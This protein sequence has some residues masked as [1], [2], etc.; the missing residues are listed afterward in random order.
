M[1]RPAANP[2]ARQ[3]HRTRPAARVETFCPHCGVLYPEDAASCPRCPPLADVTKG[4]RCPRCASGLVADTA[5]DVVVD[6]CSSCRGT[7]FDV[8]EVNRV[9][10]LTT[11]GLTKEQVKEVEA[12]LAERAQVLH[13]A[14]P[15]L[16]CVRCG[17]RMDR[18]LVAPRSQVLVDV[19][20][21]HGLWFDGG[22][23]EAFSEFVA[24]HGL[25]VLRHWADAVYVP[26]R[27]RVAERRRR[28]A[29]ED[30]ERPRSEFG[31]F[32]VMALGALLRAGRR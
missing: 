29:Q 30:R 15:S 7:W 27:K 9:V 12:R 6:R 28:L 8:G 17:K 32:L 2:G 20:S 14:D 24:N 19:C 11:R 5:A 1:A 23:V 16:A 10:D 22:E 25:E 21:P 26:P 3:D 31:D 4:G 18:R 13:P